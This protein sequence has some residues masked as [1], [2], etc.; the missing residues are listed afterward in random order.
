MEKEEGLEIHGCFCL[1]LNDN[2][3]LFVPVKTLRKR[4]SYKRSSP[5]FLLFCFKAFVQGAC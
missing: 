3:M 5:R 1:V 2:R 4:C